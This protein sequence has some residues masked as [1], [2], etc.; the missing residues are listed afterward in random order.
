[1]SSE[2]HQIRPAS[3]RIEGEGGFSLVEVLVASAVL[4]TGLIAVAQMFIASTHQNMEA[5]RV[6]TTAV[7]AQQKIE[8]LR[9]LAWGF[10]EFGLPVSDFS[11]DITV[12]PPVPADG[13]GLQASPDF[14]LF[15]SADRVRGL[16]RRLRRLG[17]DRDHAAAERHLRA[18]LVDRSAADEPEQHAGLPGAGRPDFTIR[19][20]DRSRETGQPQ[21]Q[22]VDLMDR[23][24]AG[25]TL[26]EMMIAMAVMLLVLGGV[27]QAFNPSLG[28]F[29]TQPEVADMQQRLRVG[30]DRLYNGIIV[31]GAGIYSGAAV[32]TL[33]QFFAPV[34]PYLVGPPPQ[35]P[36]ARRL[37]PRRCDHDLPR[38][39]RPRRSAPSATRCRSRRPR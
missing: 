16:P 12:T 13:V 24:D 28:S 9:A 36:G 2:S 4:M 23:R 34:L 39:R 18:A 32:G 8:Q 35:R 20:A 14:S 37:L 19:A 11:T 30:T 27:F 15:T 10:D 3:S 26:V 22:E 29:Q 21:D 31:A 33:G 6:T 38:A 7:L 5:R 17:R 25:F 1:M